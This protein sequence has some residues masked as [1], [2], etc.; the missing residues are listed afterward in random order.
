MGT[1]H[2]KEHGLR[3]Y[4]RSVLFS[5]ESRFNVSRSDGRTRV[6]RR[7]G[8]RFDRCCVSE[9][10]RYGGGSV[11][12]WGAISFRRR[13]PLHFF[14]GRV[15]AQVYLEQIIQPVVIPCFQ[16]HNELRIFQQDNARPHTARATMDVLR[17]QDFEIMDWPPYSP[18]M[19]PI[20]H[21]WDELGRR[22]EANHQPT[23][24]VEL[25]RALE[26][27]WNA[28]PQLFLRNLINSMR[29]RVHACIGARGA[30]TRY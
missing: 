17:Q 23:T 22:V 12:V 19:S 29:N 13:T 21:L 26:V 20:E 6:W 16:M 18:D 7:Q 28:I 14:T 4:W 5:D 11:H 24:V 8:E 3:D 1:F 10:D 25:E 30:H 2:H 27:E 15:N 9:R